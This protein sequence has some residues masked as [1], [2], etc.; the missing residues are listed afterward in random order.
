MLNIIEVIIVIVQ[1]LKLG[2]RR[3]WWLERTI[4]YCTSLNPESQMLT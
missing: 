4:G 2:L 3:H 1:Q